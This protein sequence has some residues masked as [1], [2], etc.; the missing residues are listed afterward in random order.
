MGQL[1][2]IHLI[3][4]YLLLAFVLLGLTEANVPDVFCEHSEYHIDPEDCPNSFYHCLDDGNGGWIVEHFTCPSGAV[5]DPNREQCVWP[6]LAPPDIC[7]GLTHVFT[8]APTNRPPDTGDKKV[9]CYWQQWAFFRNGRGK[10]DV[11]EI[12]PDLCTHLNYGWAVMD[13]YHFNVKPKSEWYDL[14]YQDC[15][16]QYGCR[17]DGYRRFNNLRKVNPELKTILSIGGSSEHHSGW[18]NMVANKNSRQVFILSAIELLQKFGFDGADLDWEHPGHYIGN[19]QN[20]KDFTA[21]VQ[22][23]SEAFKAQNLLFSVALSANILTAQKLYDVPAISEAVD[24]INIKYDYDYHET[25]INKT[26]VNAPLYGRSDEDPMFNVNDT[27]NW[28]I[29]EG[30][31]SMKILLGL[32]LYGRGWEMTLS[33]EEGIY[34]PARGPIE[35]GPLLNTEGIWGYNEIQEMFHDTTRK[36]HV[37]RDGCYKT[38]FAVTGHY[39]IGYDDLESIRLKSQFINYRNLGGALIFSL[40]T[41]DFRA[42]FSDHKY[43]MTMEVLRVLSTGETLEPENIIGENDECQTATRCQ[44][45]YRA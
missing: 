5:F 7:D 36:W 2:I 12:N 43:P 25:I 28:Y 31:P 37:V 17:F 16:N 33:G 34:C 3:A 14:G 30:A 39:W 41:D 32:G 35:P 6:E 18:Y 26:Y 21:L 40:D 42:D 4:M 13:E 15:E 29:D 19:E 22:E 20:K 27:V 24:W 11:E 45:V 44:E 1:G 9:V 10:M 38:P 8:E 23:M